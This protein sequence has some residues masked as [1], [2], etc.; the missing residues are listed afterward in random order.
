MLSNYKSTKATQSKSRNLLGHESGATL[1]YKMC[2]YL[3]NKTRNRNLETKV[4][5]SNRLRVEHLFLRKARGRKILQET[6]GSFIPVPS[7][8]SVN[9][10]S[11]HTSIFSLLPNQDHC[12]QE[13]ID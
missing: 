12:P 13:T 2:A 11:Y 1:G 6:Q 8:A 9:S 7:Y 10:T 3:K 4:K 5:N